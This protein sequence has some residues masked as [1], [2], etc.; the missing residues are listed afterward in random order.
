MSE[1]SEGTWNTSTNTTTTTVTVRIWTT[2]IIFSNT[3]ASSEGTWNHSV[4]IPVGLS[5]VIGTVVVVSCMWAKRIYK[6]N[7]LIEAQN[8]I[9]T[10]V[11]HDPGHKAK[12]HRK[13]TFRKALH[14]AKVKKLPGLDE[15]QF[16]TEKSIERL[17][18]LTP[19]G[20]KVDHDLL[21][22]A[23]AKIED[24][25][26][27]PKRSPS[28]WKKKKA[29]QAT[30]EA[31]SNATAVQISKKDE[32]KK[33]SPAARVAVEQ[34]INT[35]HDRWSVPALDVH[36][37]HLGNGHQHRGA[38]HSLPKSMGHSAPR[39]CRTHKSTEE[40]HRKTQQDLFHETHSSVDIDEHGGLPVSNGHS[41]NSKHP[42][43]HLQATPT[44]LPHRKH[45]KQHEGESHRHSLKDQSPK[46][47]SKDHT[48]NGHHQHHRKNPHQQSP[49][50]SPK[51]KM[52]SKDHKQHH[53]HKQHHNPVMNFPI[54]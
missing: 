22:Q 11:G 51:D 12:L 38:G 45:K 48:S 47:H 28:F 54:Q 24:L 42:R 43:A 3:V 7:K 16:Q 13:S 23:S 14:V 18:E 19:K 44:G 15:M 39:P 40:Y 32:V 21:H 46:D 25:K 4:M 36:E 1:M 10:A 2:T 27:R 17:K 5:A 53:H 37:V 8:Q 9:E 30:A 31:D 26:K 29:Q 52:F 34:E 35:K 6:L 50:L 20:H 33:M 41:P 49:E